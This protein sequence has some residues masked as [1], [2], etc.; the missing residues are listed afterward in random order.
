MTNPVEIRNTLIAAKY[1]PLYSILLF[2]SA[3]FMNVT[4]KRLSDLGFGD[5]S[6][7][8]QDLC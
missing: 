3:G 6:C 4:Y 2:G 7:L 1:F 5:F 8:S